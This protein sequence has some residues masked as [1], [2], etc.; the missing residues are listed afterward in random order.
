M[1][2]TIAAAFAVIQA[3]V[4]QIHDGDTLAVRIDG[5]RQTVRIENIDTPEMAPR[6]LCDAEAV[7]A[8]GARDALAALAPPGS[9]VTLRLGARIT[10]RYGRLLAKVETSDGSDSGQQLIERGY[11]RPWR[12]RREPWCVQRP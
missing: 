6:A 9:T 7:A 11:A 8:I 4:I 3:V 1:T 5:E 12:G 2:Q 10:D